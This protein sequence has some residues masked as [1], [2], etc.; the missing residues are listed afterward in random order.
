MLAQDLP[1]FNGAHDVTLRSALCGSG[2]PQ[3]GA[4]EVDGAVLFQARHDK[5]RSFPELVNG[6]RCRL[7]VVAIETG[8][9][10]VRKPQTSHGNWYRPRHRKHP[11]FWRTPLH[12]CG[13]GHGCL[14]QHVQ[15]LSLSHWLHQR[16]RL[17]VSHKVGKRH[18]LQISHGPRL[19]VYK[20][21]W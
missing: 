13:D 20:R 12:G 8:A 14:R 15:C 16:S 11:P 19:H 1:C 17:V 3:P 5:E 7:V 21:I 10:G 2:E 4:A 18:P 9:D 6:R